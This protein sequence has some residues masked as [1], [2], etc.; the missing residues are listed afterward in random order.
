MFAK[1]PTGW[2]LARDASGELLRDQDGHLTSKLRELDWRDYRRTGTVALLLL[3]TLAAK[4]N[5]ENRRH[6]RDADKRVSKVAITYKALQSVMKVAPQ[7]LGQAISLLEEWGAI[8]VHQPG[9]SST[10]ELLDLDVYGQWSMYPQDWIES[11]GDPVMRFQGMPATKMGLNALKIYI[12]LL[13]LLDNDKRYTTISYSG[14]TRWTGVRREEIRP[15]LALLS[16]QQ[17][18]SLMD[19]RDERHREDPSNRYAVYGITPRFRAKDMVHG[20]PEPG[21]GTDYSKVF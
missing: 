15:A 5:D 12:V 21:Q 9:R 13:R 2:L 20:L 18:I 3:F 7:T 4:L 19:I 16:T 8:R 17:L 10:Y 14:L 6:G 1:L 11:A